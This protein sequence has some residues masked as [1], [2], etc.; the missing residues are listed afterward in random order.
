MKYR[1]VGLIVALAIGSPL[2]NSAQD[3]PEKE[4]Q[5][6]AESWLALVDTGKSAESWQALAA[7]ARDSIGQWR[8]KIGFAMAEKKF[9]PISRRT[10]RS[11]KFSTKSPSG[12]PGEFVFIEFGSTSTKK[13]AVTEKLATMRES[14]RQW[15]VVT[16]TIE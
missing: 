7:P 2:T 14:D 12:R 15:R 6:A 13:S 11:A 8:W 10:L 4:A 5:R 1:L 16:Y 3:T 9:G